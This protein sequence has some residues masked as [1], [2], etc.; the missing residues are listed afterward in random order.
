MLSCK[1]LAAAPI[2]PPLFKYAGLILLLVSACMQ[3]GA[4][5]APTDEK[6]VIPPDLYHEFKPVPDTENAIINWR[7]AAAVMAPL[8][9]GDIKLISSCWIPGLPEPSSDDLNHLNQWLQRNHDALQLFNGSLKQ[10]YAQWPERDPQNPQPELRSLNQMIFARLFEAD[11][12]AEH[13]NFAGA[14][15]FLEENLKLADDGLHGDP[16]LFDYLVACTQRTRTQDAILRLASRKSVPVSLLKELLNHLPSLDTEVTIYSNA[17]SVDFT[18]D[19][20]SKYDVK[21][22]VDAWLKI[23]QTNEVLSILFST[24]LVR[25]AKVILDPSLVAM[26]PKPYDLNAQLDRE[27]RTYRIYR[28]NTLTVYSNRDNSLELESEENEDQLLADIKPLMQAVTGEP[29]PLSRPAAQKARAAYLALDNP[30]GRV[31]NC[32]L[33]GFIAS[34]LKVCECRT[35]REAT[36]TCMALLIFEKQKGHL[37]AALSDL[38]DEKILPSL[39]IDQFCG[40]PLNYSRDAH[41]VWSVNFDGINDGG[42]GGKTRWGGK[43]AVW[44]IPELN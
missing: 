5:S 4:A 43:D 21:K 33:L 34:D 26:H 25:P 22:T 1:K 11:Q 2:V 13:G 10:P 28:D 29:L 37:P 3:A 18:R 27:T 35:E 30:I 36:R 32:S 9:A 31:S 16:S 15:T 39:P 20:Y 38:V 17:I 24:N 8:E 23:S 42:S 6:P 44:Q 19:Y 40:A 41:K 7:R 12:Q 14:A